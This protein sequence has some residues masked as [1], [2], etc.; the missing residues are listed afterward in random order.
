M[1][2]SK[3]VVEKNE[4]RIEDVPLARLETRR[5]EPCL[6]L[7]GTTVVVLDVFGRVVGRYND[8]GGD[9]GCTRSLFDCK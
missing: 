6:V 4:N 5:L 2:H 8:G 9:V 1:A 3:Q 7:S